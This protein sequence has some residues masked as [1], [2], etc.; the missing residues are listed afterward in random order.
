M[1][2][3]EK[4]M[5]R[6]FQG[7]HDEVGHLGRG[8]VLSLMKKF[9]RLEWTQ[10]W[11]ITLLLA[12][13]VFIAGLEKM[14]HLWISMHQTLQLELSKG[15]FH[16]I[17]SLQITLLGMFKLMSARTRQQALQKN[18][19]GNFTLHCG[20]PEKIISDQGRNFEP[21]L[22]KDLCIMAGVQKVRTRLIH[23]QTNEQCKWCN[24]TFLNILDTFEPEKKKDWKTH[25]FYQG[26]CL[27]LHQDQS[28][29]FLSLL[30]D[31]WKEA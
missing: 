24:S 4:L 13:D 5:K 6:A 31:V 8:R 1:V 23:S 18:F 11:N 17:L 21:N 26:T 14:F 30:L 28:H 25:V 16:N 19:M 9:S 29:W 20:F 3:P 7:C 10:M 12:D 22:I 27:Q 15:K 2:V